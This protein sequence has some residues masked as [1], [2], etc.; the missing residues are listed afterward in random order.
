MKKFWVGNLI[1]LVLVVGFILWYNASQKSEPP[2]TSQPIRIGLNPWIGHGEYYIAKEK[3][4]FGAEKVNVELVSFDDNAT[5]KQLINTNKI[6]AIS[7]TPETIIVLNDAGV[8]VKAVAITDSSQGADGI[9]ASK[10]IKDISGLKGKKVA[11]EVGSPSH[12]FLSYFLDQN[13]LTTNDL[14]VVNEIAPDA[15]ATFVAGKVDAAVTW[16]PW[17]SKASEREGGHLLISSKQMQVFPDYLIFREE[18]VKNRPQDIKA[19][20]KALFAAEQWISENQNEAVGIIANKFKITDQEVKDQLPTFSWLSYEDN[21]SLFVPENSPAQK[22]VQT[23][24]DLWLKLGLIKT[25]VGADELI[26]TSL[27][28][29][30]YK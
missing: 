6:D 24:S 27:V 2:T 21:L 26:D 19:V 12:F 17:L 16:E 4:F 20:L 1:I 9:V 11:F 3:G 14:T 22:L 28:K 8:K 5:G 13:R 18:V 7:F 23:A 25:K 10:D 15:G 29:N 30:L